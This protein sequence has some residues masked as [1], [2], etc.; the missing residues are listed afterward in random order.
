MN[1]LRRLL[2]SLAL[3]GAHL[4]TAAEPPATAAI[5]AHEPRNASEAQLQNKYPDK[6]KPSL[7]QK[8]VDR[9]Q[10]ASAEEQVWLRTLED[11]LGGFYFPHYLIGLFGPKPYDAAADAWAYVKDDP[12][13]PRVLI[14][15][16][17]ISRAYTANVRQTL[18]G[19]A[20]VHR[21]PANCGPTGRFLEFGEV[22]LNQ[23]G[24]NTWDFIVVNFGIHDG[25]NV[26]GYEERLHQVMTRLKAT[27]AKQIFWVRTTPWGKDAAV[28]ESE[29]GDASRITNPISDRVANAEGLAVIDAHAV[30]APLIAT[31]L[32]RKDF[33]HWTPEAYDTLGKT[34]AD[35]LSASM[36]PAAA[37]V[38]K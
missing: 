31:A 4:L 20:N 16:D 7:Y 25:R 13:L 5:P 28:F 9:V 32:G 27:G 17:S 30:M 11:Q 21:A 35:A 8:W 36:N 14:I 18:Q 22:W 23:N 33:T 2:C 24:S 3:F 15:G 37:A 1:L 38:T 34:V 29:A 12:A 6:I 10:A 19:K 26:K